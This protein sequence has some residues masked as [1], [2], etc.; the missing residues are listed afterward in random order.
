MKERKIED[1]P[2][3]E[4]PSVNLPHYDSPVGDPPVPN[5][6]FTEMKS[7]NGIDVMDEEEKAK[8]FMNR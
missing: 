5:R 3:K 8:M 2:R 1:T 4:F 6:A 7:G